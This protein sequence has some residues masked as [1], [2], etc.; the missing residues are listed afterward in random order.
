MKTPIPRWLS[1]PL[2]LLMLLAGAPL[3]EAYYDPGIQRWINRDPVGE[4]GDVN[5]FRFVNNEPMTIS[6]PD[7]RTPRPPSQPA[8]RQ[9]LTLLMCIF[10]GEAAIAP[11]PFT[12]PDERCPE[13]YEV[14]LCNYV[15]LVLIDNC[16]IYGDEGIVSK[17]SMSRSFCKGE[18]CPERCSLF[19]LFLAYGPP[20]ILR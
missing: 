9:C 6:D 1:T 13:G 15:C 12:E 20:D 18:P 4:P 5:L 16:G 7:G 8:P 17:A 11:P 19:R 14:L 10:T 3:A 2:L